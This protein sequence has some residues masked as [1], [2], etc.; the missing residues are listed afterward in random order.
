MNMDKEM[1]QYQ[2][3][4][5]TVR[6]FVTKEVDPLAAEIDRREEVPGNC[7]RKPPPSASSG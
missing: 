7:W 3:I 4:R 5:Q 6:N 2:L 1:E